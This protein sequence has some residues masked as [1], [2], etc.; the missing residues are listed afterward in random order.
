[1]ESIPQ[2]LF[3]IQTRFWCANGAILNKS[4]GVGLMG[5]FAEERNTKLLIIYAAS[6]LTA[7]SKVLVTVRNEMI[8]LAK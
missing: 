4:D 8:Q 3:N 7:A 5:N 1:M 2:R 6:A